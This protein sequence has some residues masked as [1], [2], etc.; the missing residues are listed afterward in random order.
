MGQGYA[1]E[2]GKEL[3]RL[4]REEIGVTEIITWPGAENQ[5][6]IRVA[7]KIGFVEGGTVEARDGGLKTVYVLPGMVF[8]SGVALSIWGEEE[9]KS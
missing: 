7:Q 4:V 8:D 6:S 2:A 3:L 1:A 9:E 5:R